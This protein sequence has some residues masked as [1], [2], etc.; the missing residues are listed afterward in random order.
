MRVFFQYQTITITKALTNI[1]TSYTMYT[2]ASI[3]KSYR[4]SI[5]HWIFILGNQC[6]RFEIW[7]WMFGTYIII[8]IEC[9]DLFIGSDILF[10]SIFFSLSPSRS[11]PTKKK[12]M[13]RAFHSLFNVLNLNSTCRR[14]RTFQPKIE[15][16][17]LKLQT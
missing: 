5:S 12:M 15:T 2:R 10:L 14:Y 3:A 1:R 8:D 16:Y 4:I 9:M 13:K 11:L 6:I 17:G 7:H